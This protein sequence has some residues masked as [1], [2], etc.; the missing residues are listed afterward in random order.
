[1]LI[2]IGKI[3]AR[4]I[5]FELKFLDSITAITRDND[6]NFCRNEH[7]HEVFSGQSD[8]KLFVQ[9]KKQDSKSQQVPVKSFITANCLQSVSE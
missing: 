5:S 2:R 6:L 8:T 3:T 4:V 7:T 1:M 9:K